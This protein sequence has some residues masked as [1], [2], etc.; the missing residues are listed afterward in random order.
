MDAKKIAGQ[1]IK[2]IIIIALLWIWPQ[3][4]LGAEYRYVLYKNA[5]N[6]GIVVWPLPNLTPELTEYIQSLG[7]Q[8][9][10]TGDAVMRFGH[11]NK[12]STYMMPEAVQ[13]KHK[14]EKVIILQ[15]LD[16]KVSMLIGILESEFGLTLPS[17]IHPM[18]EVRKNIPKTLEVF[19]QQ[20]GKTPISGQPAF[21]KADD[22]LL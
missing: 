13:K 4:A 3:I 16:D 9:V 10:E 21:D 6:F 7:F 18:D 20:T 8:Q 17:Q 1:T 22:F 14:I 12:N 15:V 2:N 5:E 19:R 11:V